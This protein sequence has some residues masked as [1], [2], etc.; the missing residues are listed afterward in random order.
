MAGRVV[1]VACISCSASIRLAWLGYNFR[2]LVCPRVFG[3]SGF[4]QGPSRE[5]L[6]WGPSGYGGA[7]IVELV[8]RGKAKGVL[9]SRSAVVPG[10]FGTW[11]SGGA[12]LGSISDR[13]W[14]DPLL[15]RS[16][17]RARSLRA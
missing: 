3:R 11:G 8:W 16:A 2:A 9:G 17:L 5:G 15:W 14:W 1:V 13:G 4:W 6:R 12:A 10:W 7:V